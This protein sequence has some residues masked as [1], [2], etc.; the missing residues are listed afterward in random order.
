MD[1]RTGH[2]CLN[3]RNVGTHRQLQVKI[4]EIPVWH[5]MIDFNPVFIEE[6]AAHRHHTGLYMYFAD[7]LL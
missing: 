5:Q 3:R 1:T 2:Q 4:G 6:P 7:V